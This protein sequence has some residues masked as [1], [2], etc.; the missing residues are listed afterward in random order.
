MSTFYAKFAMKVIELFPWLSIWS[1][2]VSAA[3]SSMI[4]R[5]KQW[6][7]VY[8][9]LGIMKRWKCSIAA[10]WMNSMPSDDLE[11]NPVPTRQI[12]TLEVQYCCKNGR[13]PCQVMILRESSLQLG[14]MK[15]WKCS[16]AARWMNSMPSDNLEQ[17]PVP[18]R[19]IE[20]LEVQY[21]CKDGR[22]PCQ[23]MNLA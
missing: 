17:N 19:Q 18:T 23:A 15:R 10:R 4:I 21:C 7:P 3:N 11:Q 9:Q 14:R 13:T 8:S 2:E 5:W 12:E 20:T 1:G 22:T 16:I 6:Y